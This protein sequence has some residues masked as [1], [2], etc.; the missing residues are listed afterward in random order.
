MFNTGV[1]ILI[2]ELNN[3]RHRNFKSIKEINSLGRQISL[4]YI[5]ED[6]SKIACI[7]LYELI[8][9][10]LYIEREMEELE[11]NLKVLYEKSNI[12]NANMFNRFGLFIGVI[13][14]LSVV[15]DITS[16]IIMT[17]IEKNFYEQVCSLRCEI[18]GIL[19]ATVI[20]SAIVWNL[21]KMKSK[22]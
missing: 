8:R 1:C 13:A 2:L 14:I 18:I 17:E 10:Q 12:D 11:K 20:I 5:A 22:D 7:E 19:I 6:S 15:L 3:S 9:K 4:P 21:I 16:F